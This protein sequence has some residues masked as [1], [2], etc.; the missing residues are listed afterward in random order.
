MPARQS[1]QAGKPGGAHTCGTNSAGRTVI[2]IKCK[3]GVVLGVEKIL[4]SR[5]LKKHVNRRIMTVDLHAGFVSARA[6]ACVLL[7]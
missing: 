4:H 1:R 6:R 3:D 2:G 5:L 7:F